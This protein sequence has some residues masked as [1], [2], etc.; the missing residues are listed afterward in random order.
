[1]ERPDL[2]GMP[3]ATTDPDRLH[4]WYADVLPHQDDAGMDGYRVLR[5]G[6]FH[7][8]VDRRDDVAPR[9]GDPTRVILDAD[10]DDARAVAARVDARGSGWLAR[11]TATAACSAPPSTPTATT[12]RSSSS[13]VNTAPPRRARV[14]R[15]PCS[16][17][18]GPSAPSPSATPTGAGNNVFSGWILTT[19]SGAM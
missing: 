13:A 8:L 6:A 19:F 16:T 12:S 4:D 2:G 7:L 17:P 11:R 14:M 18:P 3:L 15:G 1:M 5:P 10:V 9:A